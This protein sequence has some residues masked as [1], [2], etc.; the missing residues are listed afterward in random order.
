M[1]SFTFRITWRFAALV[2]VTTAVVLVVGGLLLDREVERGLELL[3]DIEARELAALLGQDRAIAPAEIARRIKHD[4]DSDSALFVIQVADLSGNVLFRSDNL[5]D[6]ILP[7]GADPDARWTANLPV[8]GSARLSS[9]T[10]GPWRLHVGS[11]LEPSNRLLRGYVRVA[12]PLFLCVAAGSIALGYAFSRATVRPLGAIAA[13]ANRIRADNLAERIPVPRGGDELASVVELLNGAFDRLQDSFEQVRRFSADASHEL[14][15]PLALVRLHLE[16]LRGRF[17]HDAEAMAGLGEALDELGR[18]HHV[19]DRLLFLAKAES[20]AVPLALQTIDAR[21]F[22]EDFA[23]DARVLAE[24]VGVVFLIGRNEPGQLRVDPH[25]LRQLLLNLVANA[26]AVSPAGARVALDSWPGE[27]IW[28][29]AISDEGPGVPAP[30][31]NRIFQR[32]VRLDQK[33]ARSATGHGLGLA[34]CR[35]I[36][37]LHHGEITAENRHDRSGLRVLLR[38]PHD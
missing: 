33:P 7:A 14:K 20:G 28:Q 38:L 17:Q 35:S 2:T 4:A 27:K 6:I 9:Y 36:V 22:L 13:T 3:H 10:V 31:L 24:D 18:M 8:L 32:F 19:V 37:A 12:A 34:I 5:G 21:R 23:G 25:L 30:E 1:T 16:K 15:T 29:L 11:L 26:V